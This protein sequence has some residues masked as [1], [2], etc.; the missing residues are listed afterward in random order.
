LSRCR[1]AIQT[2][3][4][5]GGPKTIDAINDAADFSKPTGRTNDQMHAY[6]NITS[7]IPHLDVGALTFFFA[8]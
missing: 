1:A 6:P 8:P 7:A 3:T 4:T 5:E 2:N